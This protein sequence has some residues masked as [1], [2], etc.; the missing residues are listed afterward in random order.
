MPKFPYALPKSTEGQPDLWSPPKPVVGSGQKW[1]GIY[2]T[3]EVK[4]SEAELLRLPNLWLR[5]ALESMG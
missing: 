3:R 5:I 2:S 4:V 1:D